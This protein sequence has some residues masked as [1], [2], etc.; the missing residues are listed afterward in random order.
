MIAHFGTGAV[1]TPGPH[2]RA[3][4]D[5]LS[6][7]RPGRCVDLINVVTRDLR[8]DVAGWDMDRILGMVALMSEEGNSTQER[9]MRDEMLQG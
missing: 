5:L 3:L 8:Q 9:R 1:S 4:G 7:I 2:E 6:P